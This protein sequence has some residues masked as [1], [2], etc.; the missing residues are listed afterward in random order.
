MEQKSHFNIIINT[1]KK[2]SFYTLGCKLNQAETAILA[3]QFEQQGYQLKSFGEQVDI[4]V[5]NTCT[6]TGKSDYRCRQMIRKAKKISPDAQ[7]AVVGCYAQLSPEKIEKIDGVDFI[8]GSDNKFKLIEVINEKNSSEIP[9]FAPSNNETFLSPSPGHFWDHTRAFLKIQDGCDSFCSYCTVPLARGRSRSDSLDHILTNANEL[10]A[11][12]HQE[13]VLTGVHI[14]KYGKDLKPINSLLDVLKALDKISDLKRIRLSSL[15][16]LEIE[17]SLIEWVADS[18]K[19][20]HH[21][22]IPLQSGDDEILKQMNRNYSSSKYS[23]VVLQVKDLIPDCGLGTDVIVGFPGESQDH[24]ENT[25]RL[26]ER[27]PFTYLHV[28][29]YSPRPGTKAFRLKDRVH[30]NE[31][32]QRSE[33]LRKV[34]KKKKQTFLQGLVGQ[35]LQVLW[36]EKQ[37]GSLMFGLTGNYARVRTQVVPELMNKICLAEISKAENDFVDGKIID[38]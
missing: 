21:F 6:V 19:V 30:P 11:R 36:E 34:G 10:V 35:K 16:P 24:F 22:H 17:R 25:V 8:L 2:I 20:C 3:E 29:S 28:F 38:R 33:I 23:D 18:E 5:I 12:G 14:G 9:L 31:I 32:K 15:E 1:M 27:L 7:I 37:K 26:V 13:I 4:C